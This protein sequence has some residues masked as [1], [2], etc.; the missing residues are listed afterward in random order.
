MSLTQLNEEMDKRLTVMIESVNKGLRERNL[1]MKLLTATAWK[2]YDAE[3]E[4][5]IFVGGSMLV[6]LRERWLSCMST[7]L[8]VSYA[9]LQLGVQLA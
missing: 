5:K 9:P 4:N 6:Q 3:K 8:E 7:H 1:S 2:V